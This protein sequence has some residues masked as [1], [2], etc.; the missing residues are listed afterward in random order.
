MTAKEKDL[1][2]FNV[3]FHA[4][5]YTKPDGSHILSLEPKGNYSLSKISTAKDI[6]IFERN[7]KPIKP[8]QFR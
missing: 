8:F 1:K 6:E 7:F 2:I 3:E 4:S 5:I